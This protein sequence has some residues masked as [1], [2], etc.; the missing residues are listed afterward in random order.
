MSR[1]PAR[2]AGRAPRLPAALALAGALLTPA[3]GVAQSIE[4]WFMNPDG[5]SWHDVANWDFDPWPAEP[6]WPIEPTIWWRVRARCTFR[7]RNWLPRSE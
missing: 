3:A 6:T 7:A 2:V 5:G 1:S 4:A